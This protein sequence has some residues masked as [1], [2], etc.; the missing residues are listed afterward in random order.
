M[1]KLENLMKSNMEN[2][3][4]DTKDISSY[5]FLYSLLNQS[6][7]QFDYSRKTREE[8]IALHNSNIKRRKNKLNSIPD[9]KTLEIN[10]LIDLETY[11]PLGKNIESNFIETKINNLTINSH[12]YGK[13]LVLIIIS[14]LL[15]VKST[16]FLGEDSN[17]ELIHVSLY[18]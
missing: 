15:V 18:N 4:L 1:K 10:S 6:S 11:N 13:Y 16:N 5:K 9:S 12:H 8:Y 14:K 7:T 17:N 3:N 2:I